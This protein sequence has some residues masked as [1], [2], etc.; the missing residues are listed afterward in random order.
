M[1]SLFYVSF[2]IR[3]PTVAE[4]AAVHYHL[5]QSNFTKTCWPRDLLLQTHFKQIMIRE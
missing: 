5:H 4:D 1:G 2:I 3:S